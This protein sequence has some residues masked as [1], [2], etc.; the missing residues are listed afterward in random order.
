MR[1]C[2]LTDDQA[3]HVG[4]SGP[5]VILLHG[6][7]SSWRA[8]L[9]VIPLLEE[10]YSVHALTLPGHRGGPKVPRDADVSRHVDALEDALDEAGLAKAHL[11]GNSLGGW[12]ALE[13]ARRG[14]AESVVVFSPAG[15]WAEARD[16]KRLARLM[17][18][19]ARTGGGRTAAFLMRTPRLRRASLR[20][21]SE[22]GDLIPSDEVPGMIED[23]RACTALEGILAGIDRHGPIAG[24]V[25][26][27]S[28]PVRVVWPDRDRTIPFERYG[29]SMLDQLP[30]A[31]LVRL[32]GIGHVPMY[33]DP[34][35]V[36]STITEHLDRAA[37]NPVHDGG[38]A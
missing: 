1:E 6:L 11:V 21:A 35:L 2:A 8:W 7:N 13:L 31:E 37:H 3:R 23:L 16:L 4:G 27:P 33:D 28:V 5:P 32:P 20:I 17:R 36:A 29:R 12:L 18:L 19:A 24:P 14:R 34:A 10:R 15:S 38:N 22:R 26:D 9:P 30:G 25:V